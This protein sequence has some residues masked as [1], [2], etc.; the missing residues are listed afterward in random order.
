[1]GLRDTVGRSGH[2]SIQTLVAP[3]VIVSYQPFNASS[4]NAFGVDTKR[5]FF[6]IVPN[7]CVLNNIN[8]KPPKNLRI[9]LPYNEL[10]NFHYVIHSM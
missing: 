7:V 5:L 2:G 3:N 9:C 1:M 4:T 8:K 6:F 10:L